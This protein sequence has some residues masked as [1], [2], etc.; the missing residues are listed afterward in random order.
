MIIL[1]KKPPSRDDIP[2]ELFDWDHPTWSDIKLYDRWCRRHGVTVRNAFDTD[3]CRYQEAR[4][5]WAIHNGIAHPEY[6][7]F[8]DLQKL[9]AMGIPTGYRRYRR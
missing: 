3:E 7:N 8:P 9:E 4:D 5:G 1:E 2:A 6:I